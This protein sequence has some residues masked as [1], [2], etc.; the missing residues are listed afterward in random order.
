MTKEQRELGR[1]A[2]G[3]PNKQRTTYRNHFIAGATHDDYAE[4]MAM[5]SDGNATRGDPSELTGGDY[6]FCLTM[7]GAKLCLNLN[8]HLGREA[9]WPRG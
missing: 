3:L 7:A 4:W 6:V 9:R 2:L 8:E 5:V 1:H